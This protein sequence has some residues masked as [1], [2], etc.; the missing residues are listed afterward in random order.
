MF[1]VAP[2]CLGMAARMAGL[3]GG[4]WLGLVQIMVRFRVLLWHLGLWF[5]SKRRLDSSI[6]ASSG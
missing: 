5:Q 2:V 4:L 3:A 6:S 1:L